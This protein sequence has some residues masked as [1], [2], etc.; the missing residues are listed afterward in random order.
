MMLPN[1]A[2]HTAED[3]TPGELRRGVLVLVVMF[4]VLALLV[5]PV[6]R[7]LPLLG[8]STRTGIFAW[9]LVGLAL[10]WMYTGMGYR[11]LLLIQLVL[12]S[13]AAAV[14]MVK[15]VL[16][17]LDIDK[18]PILRILARHLI[19]AGATCAGVNLAGMLVA[20]TMR[21]TRAET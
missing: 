1:P 9:L 2:D 14:I 21:R 8:R 18:A 20:A 16:V 11:P 7:D 17:A 15:L 10:F 5:V 3:A 13:A 6:L 4:A 12:F 19:L